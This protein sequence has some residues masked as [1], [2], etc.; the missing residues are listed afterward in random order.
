[1]AFV[2]PLPASAVDVA[3]DDASE[4]AAPAPPVP[5]PYIVVPDTPGFHS[6]IATAEP[7]PD[8]PFVGVAGTLGA[9]GTMDVYRIPPSS[10]TLTLRLASTA[11]G[12]AFGMRLTVFD[13]QG[14]ILGDLLAAGTIDLTL[15]LR[16]IGEDGVPV[17]VG[18]VSMGAPAAPVAGCQLWVVRQAAAPPLA[19]VDQMATTSPL[20]GPLAVVPLTTSV[21]EGISVAALE[22]GSGTAAVA[23]AGLGAGT[24][25]LA[26]TL[27]AAPAGGL[28]AE[29][30]PTVRAI[31]S[32][33]DG[34]L[35]LVDAPN[36]PSASGSA[37]L[38]DEFD[39]IRRPV[40]SATLVAVREP[41]GAP[42]LGAGS[43][44]DWRGTTAPALAASTPC[45]LTGPSRPIA[46]IA[47][48][49]LPAAAV[50]SSARLTRDRSARP[51]SAAGPRLAAALTVYTLGVDRA[52]LLDLAGRRPEAERIRKRRRPAL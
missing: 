27:S 52:M 31:G 37:D 29:G 49:A 12:A 17:F 22:A 25:A 40:A 5:G 45:H 26:P 47:A 10:G 34:G 2:G 8:D 46:A 24:A 50:A 48:L 23:P 35:D 11:S 1:M 30:S 32:G 21:S 19:P 13:A 18:V 33:V 4:F 39:A 38:A 3:S 14:H 42:M 51:T 7:L 43:L 15:D 44:G 41:G 9:A 28:L 16:R 20:S 6:T 36:R